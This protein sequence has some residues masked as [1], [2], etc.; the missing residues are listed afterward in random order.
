MTVENNHVTEPI[1]PHTSTD[2][3]QNW[4]IR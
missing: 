2:N 4:Q 3:L 1:R